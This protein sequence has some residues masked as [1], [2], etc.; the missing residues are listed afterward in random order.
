[1]K[2]PGN[3][4]K[5]ANRDAAVNIK[6]KI[7]RIGVPRIIHFTFKGFEMFLSAEFKGLARF[8]KR[9]CVHVQQRYRLRI[10]KESA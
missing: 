3:M 4:G 9:S 6:K 1:M 2:F 5:G 8:N 10:T 7:I